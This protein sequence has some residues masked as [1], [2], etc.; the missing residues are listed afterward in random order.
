MKI[1]TT[2]LAALFLGSTLSSLR[3]QVE[4]GAVEK[5]AVPREIKELVEKIAPPQEI[6]VPPKEIHNESPAAKKDESP[7][8][9]RTTKQLGSSAI[10][11][12]EARTFNFSVPAPR[13]QILDRNGYPLAQ[14]KV[15]YYA[16]LNFPYLPDADDQTI[17][18][19]AGEIIIKVNN[20]L[21]QEWDLDGKTV[22]AHY[23]NRRWLPLTFSEPLTG[24][25][26]QDMQ[27]LRFNGLILHPVYLR[28]YPQ[29]KM[30]SHVIGYVGERPPRK[31]G[32]IE[33][34]EPL[35]R[36]GKGIAGLEQHFD[37]FLT[38]VPGQ[39]NVLFAEDGTKI[40][41]ETLSPP[42]PGFNV[43][44]T[45]DIDMQ[46]IAE[47]QLA[48]KMKRGAIVIMDVRNGDIVAMASFPQFNPNDFIPT[49]STEKYAALLA[50][51]D[52]PTIPRAFQAKYP[53][54]STFK[55]L[56]ALAALENRVVSAQSLYDCPTSWTIGDTVMHNW[57]KESEGQM[58]V[59]GALMRSCN[60]WFYEVGV[61]TGADSMTSM[62]FRLGMGVKTGIPLNSESDGFIPTNRWS[63]KERGHLLSSGDEANIAIGQGQVEATPLQVARMMA[64]IA[65]RQSVL[66]PRLVRQIQ[67]INHNVAKSFPI[68]TLNSLNI[69]P[70]VLDT[71]TQG[72]KNV[73]NHWRGTGKNAAHPDVTIAGKTGTGQWR[74]LG[75]NKQ[76]LA[77]FAGFMPADAP[78]YSFAVLYEGDPG[79]KVGGGSKAAPVIGDFFKEYLTKE[80]LQKLREE[81]G[82]VQDYMTSTEPVRATPSRAPIFRNADGSLVAQ[83]AGNRSA[84]EFDA[85]GLPIF[86]KAEETTED[87]V[88]EKPKKKG[89]IGSI[90]RRF[91]N[92]R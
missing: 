85:D 3:A 9:T 29:Q 69:E 52:L 25:Q 62:A 33:P 4:T 5:P 6:E 39:I 22:L 35:W 19:V 87:E 81:S 71:V 2:A 1:F 16:A 47:E 74:G 68:E 65:N 46:R 77:W 64:A 78:V 55:V 75:D 41:E 59:V 44:T 13:G 54:A 14:N 92:G 40:K 27:R 79:E 18:K 45:I 58:N 32:P 43:I 20:L 63:Y 88:E 34:Y 76:N 66:K 7:Q 36:D 89:G 53:P 10:V 51:P 73:V 12:T 49:I 61:E 15:A 24:E 67:D 56:V 23:K 8:P 11:R 38:G 37:D 83:E 30:L 86:N 82:Q 84:V 26:V 80:N 57:A 60:T 91:R 42:K 31:L 48:E 90:F 50:N 72:M 17:L 70:R 21:G 28:H